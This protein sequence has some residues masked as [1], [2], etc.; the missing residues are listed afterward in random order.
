M[1][2]CKALRDSQVILSYGYFDRVAR[3]YGYVNTSG[4][5]QRAVVACDKSGNGHTAPRCIVHI[6]I[7]ILNGLKLNQPLA[8]QRLEYAGGLCRNFT[9][10]RRK[11]ISS[12]SKC[13]Q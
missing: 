10:S 6:D 11:S 1:P 9:I 13:P 4:E 2:C 5:G 7:H 8:G 3:S 12:I